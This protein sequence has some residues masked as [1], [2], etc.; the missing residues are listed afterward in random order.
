MDNYWG[1][2]DK[3]RHFDTCCLQTVLSL[4]DSSSLAWC[5]RIL[6]INASVPWCDRIVLINMYTLVRQ[7]LID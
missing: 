3:H 6:L 4:S 2:L 1:F 7:H 5:D